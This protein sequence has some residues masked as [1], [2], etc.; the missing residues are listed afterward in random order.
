[1]KLEGVGY[2]INELCVFSVKLF[3]IDKCLSI[4]CHDD[5]ELVVVVVVVL[6][7]SKARVPL[8]FVH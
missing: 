8:G 5:G 1:M 4:I 6:M 3:A 2:I 7:K